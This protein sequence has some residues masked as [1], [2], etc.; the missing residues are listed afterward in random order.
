MRCFEN[1]R[2]AKTLISDHRGSPRKILNTMI[3]NII[4]N[5]N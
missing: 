1:L 3:I 5:I 2:D 4:T